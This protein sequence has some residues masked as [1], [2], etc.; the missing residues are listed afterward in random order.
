MTLEDKRKAIEVLLCAG[1]YENQI[2]LDYAFFVIGGDIEVGRA[3]LDDVYERFPYYIP[4]GERMTEAA[5]HLIESSPT[6]RREWFGTKAKA[7]KR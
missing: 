2:S 6:L 3:A 7:G 4:F 1:S 5:Y